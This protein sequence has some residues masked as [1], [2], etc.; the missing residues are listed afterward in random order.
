MK[1]AIPRAGLLAGV[2]GWMSCL[3]FAGNNPA[4]EI[5]IR[6]VVEQ[7]EQGT[8]S[9]RLGTHLSVRTRNGAI[10]VML[11]PADFIANAGFTFAPG[12]AVRIA[13]FRE[14]RGERT[15]IFAREVVK[16]G[17]TLTLRDRNRDPRWPRGAVR[18]A[19]AQS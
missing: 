8:D 1:F 17:R 13:G 7:V 14:T 15:I 12:D 9:A 6:G 11:G 5:T 3:A 18:W 16:D 19:P 2:L 4:A 10:C